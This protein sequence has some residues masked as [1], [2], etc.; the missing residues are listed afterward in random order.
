MANK[1]IKKLFFF[2]MVEITLALAVI[3]IG[4]A[5]IMSLFPVALQ[6]TRDSIADNYAA[7]TADQIIAMISIMARSSWSDFKTKI[8][9]GEPEDKD[10]YTKDAS[11]LDNIYSTSTTGVYK[12]EQKSSTVVD[13]SAYIKIWRTQLP[14]IEIGGESTGSDWDSSYNYGSG[15]HI[16]ICYPAELPEAKRKKNNYYFEVFKNN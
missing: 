13:F 16:Q 6:S 9:T 1:P 4:I 5:G 10:S 11:V 12:I 7:D 15:V 2:N 8:Q 3:G 14:A